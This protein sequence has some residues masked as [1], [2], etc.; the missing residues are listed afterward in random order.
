MLDVSER[1]AAVYP[2]ARI[3]ARAGRPPPAVRALWLAQ[4]NC[5]YWHG[6][7][8]GTYL[9]FLRQSLYRNLL[10]AEHELARAGER[11]RRLRVFDLDA[12]DHDEAL[13]SN[14][15]LLMVVAPADGGA[16]VELSDRERL[17][18]I[19][20]TLARRPE[21]YHRADEFA[22]THEMEGQGLRLE[23]PPYP[24]DR[25]R[26][27]C[28]IDRFF[29][30]GPPLARASEPEDAGE[31]AGE[32]YAMETR[33]A[34][35]SSIVTL[36]REAAV[37]GGVMRVEKTLRLDD[38]DGRRVRARY[39]LTSVS[40]APQARF[41]VE[42][43]F[44]AY[45]P[46]HLAGSVTVGDVDCSLLEGG[47]GVGSELVLTLEDPSMQV[48]VHSDIEADIDAR[49]VTTMSQSEAGLE[50]IRQG[51]ACVFTWP[52]RLSPGDRFAVSLDLR[53]APPPPRAT[54]QP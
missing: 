22:P 28:F 52:L 51:L 39:V 5:A 45:F 49:P 44:A 6:L 17:V 3:G 47:A 30:P 38:R 9:P 23:G 46:E 42:C 48:T 7:F 19:V 53:V 20:D 34:R 43:N 27:G 33:R 41:G 54:R 29:P 8:G 40:G 50:S 13:A 14:E 1:V 37:P 31:F 26:R 16:I 32:P 24:Y 15:A 10:L 25:G 18:N 21:A 36:T 2:P 35:G 12:D 4:A 11:Q